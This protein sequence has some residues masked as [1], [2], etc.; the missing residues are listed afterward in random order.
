[1]RKRHDTTYVTTRWRVLLSN[2]RKLL[3]REAFGEPNKGWPKPPM[4][5]GDFS[6][7]QPAYEN[8][9]RIGHRAKDRKDVVALR[10]GPPAPRDGFAGDSFGK[11]RRGPFGRSEDDAMPSERGPR[12][13]QQW[14]SSLQTSTRHSASRFCQ[15]NDVFHFEDWLGITVADSVDHRAAHFLQRTKTRRVDGA[16]DRIEPGEELVIALYVFLTGSSFHE[17][18]SE[19]V[20]NSLNNRIKAFSV[21][22]FTRA[23][24]I[25]PCSLLSVPAPVT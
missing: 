24:A 19:H 3:G 12:P 9:V 11:A 8:L 15:F 25:R 13:P 18:G 17:G 7:D 21:A 23:H 22:P 6:T 16:T 1:M 20:Q 5:Q 2:L 10:M 14:R 4:N